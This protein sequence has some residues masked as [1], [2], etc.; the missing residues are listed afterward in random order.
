MIDLSIAEAF[1]DTGYW[2]ALLNRRDAA[3]HRKAQEVSQQMTARHIQVVT[4][5][6]VLT[7]FLNFFS[8]FGPL[9]RKQ[10]AEMVSRLQQQADV[11]IIRQDSE[12]FQEA[13]KLYAQYQDKAWGHTDCASFLLMRQRGITHALAYDERF[14]QAGFIALL[15]DA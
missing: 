9:F 6:M 12:Q 5:E 14:K 15:R 1:A 3:L 4:S 10:A 13:L 2:I 8:K 7:E 11:T